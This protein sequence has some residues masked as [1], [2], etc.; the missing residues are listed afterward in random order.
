MSS[1]QAANHCI[2]KVTRPSQTC[3]PGG[4][5]SQG[6][7]SSLRTTYCNLATATTI[8]S[9]YHSTTS[10]ATLF[11]HVSRLAWCRFPHS[12]TT[13]VIRTPLQ[14]SDLKTSDNSSFPTFILLELHDNC[15]CM[16]RRRTRRVSR[17]ERVGPSRTNIY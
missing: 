16:V 7:T 3:D 5:L 1:M 6:N 11:L 15:T 13:D 10:S 9:S 8:Y 14:P 4:Q 2:S 17:I 12:D